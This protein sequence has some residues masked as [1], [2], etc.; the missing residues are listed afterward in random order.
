MSETVK[1]V[2]KKDKRIFVV[3]C[4]AKSSDY[5]AEAS[6]PIT[7]TNPS[8]QQYRGVMVIVGGEKCKNTLETLL[9]MWGVS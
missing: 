3:P 6:G 1:I 9:V 5:Y 2:E 7:L 4:N 8:S